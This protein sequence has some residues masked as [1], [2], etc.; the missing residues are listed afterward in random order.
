M[1]KTLIQLLNEPKYYKCNIKVGSKNGSGFWYCG[2]ASLEYALDEIDY[3]TKKHKR[4]NE[5]ML[6]GFQKRLES[7]E[8]IYR[9]MIRHAEKEKQCPTDQ[10]T[11]KDIDKYI[12]R[13]TRKKEKEIAELPKLIASVEYDIITP[14]IDRPVKEIIKGIS[15]EENPC[16][17]IY[18]Q[19]NEK[20][21]Y[22]TIKEYEKKRKREHYD[23]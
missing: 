12:E 3:Q 21:Q 13:M 5:G 15:P 9:K 1:N 20:G 16:Y 14:F 22:W 23:N 19:G 11:I 2:K 7:I 18:V 6:K 8:S 4:I 10:Q 17:V